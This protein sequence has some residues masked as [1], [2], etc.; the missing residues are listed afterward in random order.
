MDRPY[1]PLMR[2]TTLQDVADAA[3]VHRSTASR[4]LNPE[5]SGRIS[6]EVVARVVEAARA[7]NYRR[8]LV[9][10]G[11]RNSRTGLIGMLV[12]DIGNPV[13]APILAGVEAALADVG[14]SVLVANARGDDVDL[15]EGLW[16]RRAEGLILATAHDD[17]K[18][19][20]RCLADRRPAVLVNRADRTGRLPAATSDD[21]QGMRL[22]AAHLITLG[23]RRIAH[24]AGP[25]DVSTGR[26]RAEGFQTALHDAGLTVGPVVAAT[27]YSREAGE[28]AA[29]RLLDAGPFTAIVAANDLL[30]LGAYR[31][32]AA[33]GLRCPDDISITGH[34]DMPLVDM[35]QPPLTTVRIN[36]DL[37]GRAAA[38]L[39]L[40]C[41]RDP[42]GPIR[43]ILAEP[44]LAVRASTA[45]PAGG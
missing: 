30:A 8:D 29:S 1:P 38:S 44:E 2:V 33:R 16:A 15:V 45:A 23:H 7:L 43:H 25:L 12:P 34:N 37:I 19:I 32:I 27:A 14:Y 13:F 40:D 28:A 9:A 3:Q 17:D 5:T 31:A 35:V 39:L 36:Q 11:M 4:A 42:D 10:A 21:R 24:L 22:A 26:L 18:V 41:I 20:A 6:P